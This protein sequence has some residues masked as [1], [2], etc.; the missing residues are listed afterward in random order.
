VVGALPY[1][2]LVKSVHHQIG[3]ELFP[4]LGAVYL[5]AGVLGTLAFFTPSGIG[6]REGVQALL[7]GSVLP[8]ETVVVVVILARLWSSVMDVSF[9]LLSKMLVPKE[10]KKTYEE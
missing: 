2:L 7:L 6:V 8:K 3:M 5:L 9:F 1:F 10:H 4:F